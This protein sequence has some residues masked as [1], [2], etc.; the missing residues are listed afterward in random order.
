M[1]PRRPRAL[2]VKGPVPAAR[3]HR[4]AAGP[5]QGPDIAPPAPLLHRRRHPVRAESASPPGPA[6]GCLRLGPP[7]VAESTTA[8]RAAAETTPG[9]LGLLHDGPSF[10][11][12]RVSMGSSAKAP[13]GVV[14]R[15]PT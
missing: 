14:K 4:P 7:S 13:A 1:R 11:R 5:S 6:P 3:S 9:P 2:Y 15:R 8:R 10:F 12:S